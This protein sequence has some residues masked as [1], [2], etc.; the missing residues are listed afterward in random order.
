MKVLVSWLAEFVELRVEPRRLAE[1]LTLAGLAVDAVEPHGKDAVL[2][3]DITTNRVDCMNVYGVAREASV[4]YGLPL[5][6]MP[7]GFDESGPPAAEALRVSI[8]APDLCPRFCARGLDIRGG[9]SPSLIRDRLEAVGVRPINAIVD[10][11]NYVMMEMGQPSHAFDLARVPEGRLRVRWA[12]AGERLVTLDGVE[13]TLQGRVGVVAGEE[14]PLALAGIMGGAASEVSDET[15]TVALEA[16]YWEPLA[17][18]RAAKALG[19]HTEASHRFE[20]S[21]DPNG[22]VTAAARIAHLLQ[23][24]GGGSVR[25]GF[26]DVHVAPRPRRSAPL[27]ARRL[28]EIVGAEI[29]E[30]RARGILE[31][32]GFEAVGEERGASVFVIPS[33]RNDVSREVDLIEEVVRHHGLGKLP[34]TIPAGSAAGGLRPWQAKERDLRD[35]LIGGGLVEVINYAFVSE[36]AAQAVPGPRAA[37]ENPLSEEQAVLRNSLVVPG[38]LTTLR[39]NLRHGRR[40]VHLFELG[41]VFQPAGESPVEERHLGVLLAG[42]A[43]PPDWSGKAR[44]FDFFDGKGL[45]THALG[46]I[47][48]GDLEWSR[49]D[50]PGFLHPGKAATLLWRGQRVGF[51]GA[52]HPEQALAWEL[53]DE[54]IVAE[55]NV[56][57][58]LAEAPVAERMRPLDRFPGVSRDLSILCDA[59]LPA[60]ELLAWVRAAGGSLLRSATVADRYDRPPVPEGKVS[61]T[62]TLLFQHSERTLTGE[63]VQRA[64]EGVIAELRRHGAEIRGE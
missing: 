3:L 45:L 36:S 57:P 15:R 13:R 10:L 6:P 64:V 2:D 40:D 1:D 59:T 4:L 42:A 33:W 50:A 54:T 24:I 63:E 60:A 9:P 22:P 51:L 53:P 30:E 55:L 25:P 47:G 39:A 26:I 18:R 5:K 7:V 43:R 11:T 56:D 44:G 58:I 41:R 61:L 21:A 16:A 29:P 35:A 14:G 28:A 49:Q 19:M 52:L 48:A 23:A 34:S 32:L 20:R 62:V 46:R 17:I 38:L 37:L 8:E 12:R 27:R 31:G